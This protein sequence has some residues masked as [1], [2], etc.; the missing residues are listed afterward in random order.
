MSRPVTLIINPASNGGRSAKTVPLVL[1]ELRRG[2][3]DVSVQLTRSLGHAAELAELAATQGRVAVAMGGDGLVGTVAAAVANAR[4]AGVV[5]VI[6]SGRG[7]DFARWMGVAR[8]ET[9]LQAITNGVERPVDLGFVN[10]RSFA[11]VASIGF[12]SEVLQ[13]TEEATLMRGSA[14]YPYATL[15]SLITWK[16]VDFSVRLDGIRRD[17]RGY[18][19]VVANGGSYGGGMK[20]APAAEIDDGYFDVVTI[21]DVS[22]TTFLKVAP[23]IF[24]GRHVSHPS[25]QVVRAKEVVVETSRPFPV[26]VDGELIGSGPL[27]ARIRPLAVRVLVP[28]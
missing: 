1:D 22:K 5:A 16:P 23:R 11:C 18:N 26:A 7:N 28:R 24:S 6:P 21:T 9:A 3:N 4:P 25:V 10:G 12:D 14:V 13:A 15:K 20:I 17:F 2:G 8:L 19:V 27:S